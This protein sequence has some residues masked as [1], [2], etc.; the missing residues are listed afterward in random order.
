MKVGIIG[1]PNVGKS[2]LFNALTKM[3]VLEGNYPFAT[4]EPNVGIVEVS[5]SRLQTLSQIFQSQKTISALIEFKDIAGLVAGASKGEGLGNQFLS[6][7]RN[8]DAI[9]HVVKCFEDPNIAHV[10][11]TNNP[12]EEID[13]IQTELA[14]ADLE[15]IEKRLLKLGKQKN[16]LDKELLQEKALLTKIKTHLTT[17]D[18]KN[19]VF[20]DEE[21]K[22]VKTFNLLFLKPSL[23]LTNIKEHDLL[24]LD[25]N[26]FY[27]QVLAYATKESKKVIP[28]C[29]QLEK[30]ISSLDF[31]EK[32]L[33]LK[34]YGLV[35]SGLT[36]L[37][38]ESYA[39]LG[40]QTYFTAG[41]KE[42]RAWSF[43]KGLKAP[44]CAR[45]IHTDLQKGFIK[46]E[47]VSYLDLLEAQ[48]FQKSKEK[49]KVRIEGKEY[50]VKDG[51]IITFRFN[52]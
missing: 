50:I 46:A 12:V 42:V 37:I 15:Q 7:I 11:E 39:L 30:E 20:S 33:F 6:H 52:V 16:K 29:V 41:P 22:L 1:L 31:A 28:L 51:D 10:T 19:L 25:S 24:S 36:K 2:T 17:Q 35:E 13:I 3:Q 45:I 40:L 21:L 9:C 14:L 34:D 26:V 4:I 43:K 47:V 48:T 38:Q 18:L 23:Y 27:Q 49:G 5:D 32:Q 44:E 8:V